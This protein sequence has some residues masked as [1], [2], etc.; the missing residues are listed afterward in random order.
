M[1]KSELETFS[2]LILTATFILASCSLI[3]QFPLTE[4]INM[5]PKLSYILYPSFS[6]KNST[7]WKPFAKL[8]VLKENLQFSISIYMNP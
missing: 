2:R 3:G 4:S 7:V 5:S 1:F 6:R 8:H